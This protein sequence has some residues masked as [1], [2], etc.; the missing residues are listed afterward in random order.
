MNAVRSEKGVVFSMGADLTPEV[1]QRDH[2]IGIF[3]AP[4]TLVEYGDYECYHTAKVQ[5]VIKTLLAVMKDSLCVVYR[6]FPMT[7]QHPNAQQA[8]EA[9]EAAGAQGAFCDMHN[10][11]FK[12]RRAL[13][14]ANLLHYAWRLDLDLDKFE[15]ELDAGTYA[16]DVREDFTG[17]VRSGVISSPTLFINGV[18]FEGP[19]DFD[20]LLNT[21]QDAQDAQSH[22]MQHQVS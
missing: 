20:T 14:R 18:R 9:V 11:L 6:H 7:N 3:N 2:Y 21:I 17:G 13:S 10:L 4:V 5:P 15:A 19:N 22:V 1:T 8:A 16:D 12:N